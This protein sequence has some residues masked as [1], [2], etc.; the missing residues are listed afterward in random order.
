MRVLIMGVLNVTPDSFSDGGLHFSLRDAVD[1]AQRMT[2][3]GADIIDVGGESTRPGAESVS[4]EEEIRRVAPVV[5]ELSRRGIRVSIDTSKAAVAQ[6]AIRSG[7]D[8]V[9]DVTAF[10]DP[11]MAQICSEAGCEVALM[12]MRGT[13]RTMQI[14]PVYDDV[15]AEVRDDLVVRA[16][17]A[18]AAGI[19]R[20]KIW[21]DPG[22]GF[23]KTV[24]HNLTLLRETSMLVATGYPVLVGAS[25][26]SFIGRVLGTME[27]ADR[28]EGTLAAHAVAVNGGATMV[29][30]HDV[31]AHRRF[32]DV[33]ERINQT[34]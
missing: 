26:K 32:F 13:P 10:S 9:N 25:R 17:Y 33:I 3:E 11:Q 21:I 30:V 31:Q 16:N 20:E 18:V 5:A 1:A 8:F 27:M 24:E 14:D 23:G 34:A 7:A 6:A 19:N 29:R 12:H 22:I 15:V 28:L 2:D 4:V